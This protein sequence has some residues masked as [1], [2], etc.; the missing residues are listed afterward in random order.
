MTYKLKEITDRLV[1]KANE[2][3]EESPRNRRG[4]ASETVQRAL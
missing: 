1:E 2:F 3:A 4:I